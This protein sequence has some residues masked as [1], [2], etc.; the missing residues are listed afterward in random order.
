MPSVQLAYHSYGMGKRLDS[1]S[2]LACHNLKGFVGRRLLV[3][4]VQL[5]S[6][7][8]GRQFLTVKRLDSASRLACHSLNGFMERGL[9]MSFI[10][11]SSHFYGRQFLSVWGWVRGCQSVSLSFNLK[12]YVGRGC[13]VPSVQLA[14]HFCR[15]FL[16]VRGWA[17]GWT[18]PVG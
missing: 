7:F 8:Y 5:A 12:G 1:A 10:Q 9:L 15:Q 4:F 18:Q 2:R 17:R 6:H 11:L 3:L 14:F 13:L 16:S